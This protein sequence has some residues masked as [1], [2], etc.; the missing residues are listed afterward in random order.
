MVLSCL[1]EWP[2][3]SLPPT[4]RFIAEHSI[5]SDP[6]AESPDQFVRDGVSVQISPPFRIHPNHDIDFLR[7]Q[8][9]SNYG[10]IFLIKEKLLNELNYL[11]LRVS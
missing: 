6:E 10:A 5:L 1:P 8:R 7:N 4:P 2:L 9:W 11:L 3:F